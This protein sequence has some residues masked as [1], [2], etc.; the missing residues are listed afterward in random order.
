MAETFSELVREAFIDPL[1]SVLIVD[2]QYPTWEEIFNSKLEGDA[3]DVDLQKR[4]EGKNWHKDPNGPLEVLTQFRAKKPGYV[5]DIHD[6][7]PALSVSNGAEGA[8]EDGTAA[9]LEADHL[10]QSDLLVLDYHLDGPVS[11]LGGLRARE[12]LKSI[13]RNKHFNLVI[14]HTEHDL[15]EALY[16]CL[17]EILPSC[18]SLFDEKMRENV[19]RLQ[20]KI[21][22]LI[23][24]EEFDEKKVLSLADVKNYFEIRDPQAELS[25]ILGL[26]MQGRGSFGAVSRYAQDIGFRNLELRIFFYWF[27]Q[28]FEKDRYPS[29]APDVDFGRVSWSANQDQVWLRT[30]RGFVAFCQKGGADLLEK[31]QKSIEAWKPTPSRLI[32]AKYRQE[33]SSSGVIAEDRALSKTHAFAYFYRDLKSP[34]NQ[35]LTPEEK[36]RL[37]RSKLK[38]HVIGKSEALTSA[39]EDAVI[40]F[41]ERIQISERNDGL[42]YEENY[43]LNL[44]GDSELSKAKAHY[45]SYVST[46]PLKDGEDQLDSGHIF[47]WDNQWWVCATPACDLQPGQNTIAFAQR[48]STCRPFTALR[49]EYV[50]S[51]YEELTDKYINSGLFCFVETRP[52]VVECLG[53]YR[54]NEKNPF[55]NGKASW[56][57]FVSEQNGLIRDRKITLTVPIFDQDKLSLKE[58]EQAE[59]VGKLRYEYALNYIQKVGASVTRIGLGY[60]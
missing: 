23:D 25:S 12:I 3:H 11:E 29:S 42:N 27:L 16:E 43:G 31:L 21:D 58:G 17:L 49:L 24:S 9:I 60:A 18:T 50:G 41:S 19:E 13:L 46:L 54:I 33:L 34:G 37:R 15:E 26:F 7:T 45:N 57:T 1:R 36:L 14:L 48:S 40:E 4:S 44:D 39:I 8:C 20:D 52:G 51:K 53:L 38:T 56:C 47:K 55:Q 22:D 30:S 32:S 35:D 2:D 28:R 10:H 5:I 59:V 6:G